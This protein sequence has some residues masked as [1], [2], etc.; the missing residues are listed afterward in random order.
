MWDRRMGDRRRGGH[1]MYIYNF[2]SSDCLHVEVIIFE[3]MLDL[4]KVHL[5]VRCSG[6]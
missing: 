6:E 4:E 3:E 1:Y 2:L 5:Y